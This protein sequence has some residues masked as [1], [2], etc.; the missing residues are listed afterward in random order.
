MNP[1]RLIFISYYTIKITETKKKKNEKTKTLEAIE[2]SEK[3]RTNVTLFFSHFGKV[4]TQKKST[5]L[6]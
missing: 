3:K 5:S 2:Q 1:S 6:I 4:F